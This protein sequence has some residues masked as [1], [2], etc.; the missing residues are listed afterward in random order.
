LTEEGPESAQLQRVATALARFYGLPG[1]AAKGV[2][3]RVL[4]PNAVVVDEEAWRR[5]TRESQMEDPPT[6]WVRGG[7]IYDHHGDR[8][9][10]DEFEQDF[11]ERQVED[12]FTTRNRRREQ[13]LA[14][15]PHL[16]L[17]LRRPFDDDDDAEPEPAPRRGG[18]AGG[19][20][21]GG[22]SGVGGNRAV[23]GA[24]R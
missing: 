10:L 14:P 19:A 15:F 9:T 18:G 6:M 2:K 22:A 11:L 20:A 21:C 3:P 16:P 13:G 4:A 5:K 23:G 7:R 17:P 1:G 12:D 24:R 8:G